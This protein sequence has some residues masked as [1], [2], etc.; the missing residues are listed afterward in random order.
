MHSMIP[1]IIMPIV[2]YAALQRARNFRHYLAQI[3]KPVRESGLPPNSQ[4]RKG[5]EAWE[6]TSQLLSQNPL[7]YY[8]R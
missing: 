2:V 6:G 4:D 7:V 5:G 3:S 1:R 8:L